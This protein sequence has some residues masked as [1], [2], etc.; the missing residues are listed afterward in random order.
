MNELKF[1]L[2]I[3][4]FLNC[5]HTRA[6]WV[7]SA[8]KFEGSSWQ[9][10]VWGPAGWEEKRCQPGGEYRDLKAAL[11]REQEHVA[12]TAPPAPPHKGRRVGPSMYT[13]EN[14]NCISIHSHPQ[15]SAV[16]SSV[17]CR[18]EFWGPLEGF[19][20]NSNATYMLI[21]LYNIAH[22]GTTLS[23]YVVSEE[24]NN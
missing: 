3:L 20:D 15:Q 1:V 6:G 13:G 11:E 22:E 18:W 4:L 12:H 2:C 17:A 16:S 21:L 8:L 14:S 23:H 5:C 9:M 24:T 19:Y 7:L 10:T